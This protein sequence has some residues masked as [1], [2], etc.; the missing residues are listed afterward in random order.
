MAF[1]I[2]LEDEYGNPWYWDGT[3]NFQL[4]EKHTHNGVSEDIYY[5]TGVSNSRPCFVFM[6]VTWVPD[7]TSMPLMYFG[8][9]SGGKWYYGF[10]KDADSPGAG[11]SVNVNVFIFSD[12]APVLPRY[13]IAIWDEKG[14]LA[15]TN[16]SKLLRIAGTLD[17]RV[18]GERRAIAGSYAIMPMVTASVAFNNG[19]A[20]GEIADVNFGTSAHIEGGITV[21]TNGL[22]K[23]G[24]PNSWG[25][26]KIK[27]GRYEW[28]QL[29]YG[30][31]GKNTINTPIPYINAAEYL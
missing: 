10:S 24:D 27:N 4:I 18:I 23:A 13:G 20:G 7:I 5:D 29:L 8:K 21:L 28:F 30:P 26:L 31:E 19:G 15:I 16:E 17:C 14:D 3:R 6:Q 25:Q 22:A 1:G 2:Y 9:G 11:I 12:Y